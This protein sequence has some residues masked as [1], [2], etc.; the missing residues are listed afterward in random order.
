MTNKKSPVKAV[1]LDRDGTI[2]CDRP[3]YY[4]RRAEDLRVYKKT[5]PALKKLRALG[6]KLFVVT[7][8]SGVA[9]K[10]F[11]LKTARQINKKLADSLKKTGA[12]IDALRFCPHAPDGGCRCRKPKPALGLELIKKFGVSPSLSYMVG[13]KKSDVDFGKNLSL[14]TVLVKT[15]HGKS[16]LLK[17]GRAL[18]P[19]YSAPDILAAANWIE[20]NEKQ[21]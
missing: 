7:N 8:Q 1:F 5:V 12:E 21:N 14:K 4:L 19:D 2:I 20:K 10:F 11:T 18:K 9:R 3:G 13:D 6:F 15:G 17:H 16:Q